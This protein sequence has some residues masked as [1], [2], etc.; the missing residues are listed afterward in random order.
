MTPMATLWLV[1]M[2]LFLI[3]EASTATITT[4]WF[5]AGA[6]AAM[7]VALLGGWIWLQI[8]VFTLVS[9]AL[10]LS[11]RPLLR[12]YIDPKKS[13]TNV[14]A[15]IGTQGK[16]EEEI[17]NNAPSGRVRLGGMSWAARSTTGEKLSAGTLVKVDKI[18]GNKVFVT[19]VAVKE[20]TI[21]G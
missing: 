7:V 19:A 17:D 9:V 2:I 14:D 15:I 8:V 6:L 13:A 11:L 12:K 18:E 10:L 3:T 21:C 1:L 5:A 16:T 20:E 4:L